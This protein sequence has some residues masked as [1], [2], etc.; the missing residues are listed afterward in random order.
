M[1]AAPRRP[2]LRRLIF[3]ALTFTS[4]AALAAPLRPAKSESFD[5]D[6]NLAHMTTKLYVKKPG[7]GEIVMGMR[8]WDRV[9]KLVDKPGKYHGLYLGGKGAESS[10]RDMGDRP[11]VNLFLRELEKTITQKGW[12]GPSWDAFVEQLSTPAGAKRASIITAREH[13]PDS[14]YAGLKL[15]QKKGYIKYLPSR[16]KLFAVNRHGFAIDGEP[17]TGPTPDRKLAVQKSLLDKLQLAAQK[18]RGRRQV[19]HFS[20]DD[21]ANY[22]ATKAGLQP[23]VDEGR[24]P[25]VDIV[26]HFTGPDNV[27]HRPEVVT[28]RRPR[29]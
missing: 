5:W 7:G 2:V 11:G 28:L 25:N 19:W 4:A 26:V 13:S 22:A 14:I 24:W 18:D 16:D 17:I 9:S 1:T 12:K 10:Y 6:V 27:D 20:D 8:E 21:W 15:L 23:L 29:I 3:L